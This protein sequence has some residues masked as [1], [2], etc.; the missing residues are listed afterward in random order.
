VGFSL[1]EV[2]KAFNDLGKAASRAGAL[3]RKTKELIA[4][5]MGVAARL[6]ACAFSLCLPPN[7]DAIAI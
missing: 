2:M 1:P 7:L 4:L 6:D 3:D 5:S